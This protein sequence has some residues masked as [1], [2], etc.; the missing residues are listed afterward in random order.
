MTKP[1]IDQVGRLLET[2]QKPS[3]PAQ[4]YVLALTQAMADPEDTG[5]RC[6][7]PG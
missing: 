3:E 4:D 2:Y 5:A 7:A 1:T 6:A